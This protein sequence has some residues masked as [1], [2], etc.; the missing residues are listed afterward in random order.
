MTELTGF[1]GLGAMGLPMARSMVRRGIDVVGFDIEP[2]RLA[3][4]VNEGVRAADSVTALSGQ[5]DVVIACL[6]DDDRMED[7]ADAVLAAGRAGQILVIAGTHSLE[8]VRRLGDRCGG[9]GLR[10]VDAPVV[11]GAGAAAH[12]TLLSLA[13][14]EPE[15]VD[16]VRP[17]LMGYSRG[18]EHV[19]HL[20]AGQLAKACNLL[21]WIHSVANFE[22]LALAKRYGVDVQRMR[23]V[24]LMSPAANEN[25]RHLESA[26]FTWQEK[27][28]DLVMELAQRGGPVLPLTGQVDQLIKMITPADVTALFHERECTYLG[29]P[30]SP[31]EVAEGCP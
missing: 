12:G 7:V 1:V 20:G 2:A 31:T 10:V 29:R 22:T 25:L 3:R 21:H 26:R 11:F 27:D 28:M 23:D 5:V 13:G 6:P 8:L 18:V 17:L 4:A 16:R 14:G 15:D 9:T 24:L 19:G 30:V